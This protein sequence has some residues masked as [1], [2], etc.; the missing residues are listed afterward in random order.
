MTSRILMFWVIPP[1]ARSTVFSQF[2]IAATR[3][4][5]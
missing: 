5:L 2:F 3:I 1:D 4:A